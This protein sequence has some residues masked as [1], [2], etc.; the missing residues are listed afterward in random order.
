[1]GGCE[2]S[3]F[4]SRATGSNNLPGGEEEI[5]QNFSRPITHIGLK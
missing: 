1:M 4:F 5:W 2:Q 3:K